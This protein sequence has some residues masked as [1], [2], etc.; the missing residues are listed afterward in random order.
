MTE[1]ANTPANPL[2]IADYRRFWTARFL[3][4]LSASGMVVII[5][6]QLYDLARQSYGMSIAQASFMLGV[7]G[8]V[9]FVPMLLLTPVSGV[10]ADRFDRR[11][12]GA[13]AVGVD[14]GMALTLAITTWQ[15]WLTLPLVLV[16]GMAHGTARV[17]VGPSVGAI[18]PM[19]V[20][21]TLLPRA[22]AMNS[23][24]M[25]AGTIAGPA[26]A[27][28]LFGWHA[29]LFYWMAVVLLCISALAL[30]TIRPLPVHAANRET[31]PMR[32]V[33]EG[34]TFVRGNP[35]LLGCITLDLF[36]VLL[37]GATALLPVYARDILHVG[38]TGLGQMRA[39]PAVGAAVL[40]ILLSF[41]PLERRV[42]ITMLASVALFGA[43]TAIFA[44]STNYA[45]S[46]AMLAVLGGADMVSMFV[47]GTLVQVHTPNEMRGRVSA[48]SGL[49]V[50]ASNEL[51][52]ME[53]GIAAWLLGAQGAVLLGGLGAVA[54]TLIWA[55]LFPQI[56]KANRFTSQEDV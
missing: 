32:M 22:I 31:H 54:V 10:V 44:V 28:M 41:R 12:V 36:A 26:V 40:G 38:P 46:L 9:Q 18:A 15:G 27:G 7:L 43:A 11:K 34:L 3:S 1:P 49:A 4:W 24:A 48:I 20:P 29:S 6:Y 45:L 17:F 23:M 16:L 21:P 19:I 47:R 37:G 35:F 14:M 33:K 56:R 39:A 8:F 55:F 50:G 52:E 30:L 53:S 51:G 2:Q 25:Q 13:I 42:G 5:G